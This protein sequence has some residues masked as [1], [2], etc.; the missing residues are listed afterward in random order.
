MSVKEENVRLVF[1]LKLRQLRLDKRLS[2]MELSQKTGVSV[3]YLNEIEKGKKY[4]KADKIILLAEAMGVKYDWLVSLTLGHNLDALSDLLESNIL[5][6]LPL[7]I[8]GIGPGDLLELLSNVPEKLAAFISTLVKISRNFEIRKEQFYFAVLRSYQEMHDNYFED[9]EIA[10]EKF[11]KEEKIP[12]GSSPD[13]ALLAGILTN[14]FGYQIEEYTDQERPALKNL[15]SVLVQKNG[16]KLLINKRLTA[17]QKAF[18]LGREIAYQCLGL[19]DRPL[20]SSWVD[21]GSFEQVLNNFKASYFSGAL[22]I[23]R[24]RIVKELH[25][26]FAQPTWNEDFLVDLMDQFH[27]TSEIFLHRLTNIAPRYFGLNQLFFLRFDNVPGENRFAL[28]KEIHLSKLHTPHGTTTEFY[29][30]RWVSL[31]ILQDLAKIQQEGKYEK[32]LSAA[33]ISKYMNSGNEY[34]VIAIARPT[35]FSNLNTSVS[36]GFLM[37]DALKNTVK[38]LRD[39]NL[40]IKLVNETCERCGAMDCSVRMSEPTILRNEQNKEALK[41]MLEDLAGEY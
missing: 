1:G 9:I 32:P 7:E 27:A 25:N 14:R 29:C 17:K 26:F 36:I 4:P 37:N 3:S 21:I 11:C 13:A 18:T 30:R 15:R 41:K 2:L 8:F 35:L 31:T 39:P 34:L 20:T 12:L 33:H 22:L 10:V 23:H 16:P 38:F 6:E 24:L 19:H 28:T 40:H 5:N